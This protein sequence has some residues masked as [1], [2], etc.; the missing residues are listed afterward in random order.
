V[1]WQG[2][3]NVEAAHHLPVWQAVRL[4]RKKCKGHAAQRPYVKLHPLA[5]ITGSGPRGSIGSPPERGAEAYT[6]WSRGD[7]GAVHV[8]GSGAVY[9]A[10]RD[11]LMGTVPSYYSKGYPCFRIQTVAPEPTSG[12]DTSLLVGPKPGW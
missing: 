9:H 5:Y 4:I 1:E 10:T 6:V 8:V 3:L 11:S 7:P 2:S 12:E